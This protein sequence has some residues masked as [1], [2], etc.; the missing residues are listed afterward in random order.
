M[1]GSATSGWRWL[2]ACGLRHVA[3][4]L[5]SQDTNEDNGV[6]AVAVLLISEEELFTK[7]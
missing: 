4:I 6:T 7:N 2:A 3:C 5:G 1:E